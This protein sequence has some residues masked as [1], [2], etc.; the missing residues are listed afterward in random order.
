MSNIASPQDRFA[1]EV[2]VVVLVGN[3]LP[4]A[5]RCDL[6]VVLHRRGELPYT[7][8]LALPSVLLTTGEALDR[9]AGRAIESLGVGSTGPLHQVAVEVSALS[10]D[11]LVVTYLTTVTELPEGPA[12][13]PDVEQVSVA[14][15][16]E[17]S[18]E[19]GDLPIHIYGAHHS[20]L[21]SALALLAG[22]VERT[23]IS[24][25]LIPETFT[26]GQIRSIY[27]AAW[28][29]RLDVR[30]FRRKLIDVPKPFLESVGETFNTRGTEGRPPELYQATDA[31]NHAVP[32][33]FPRKR[34]R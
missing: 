18:N 23:P 15:L 16:H 13:D 12:Q 14:D 4:D 5:S 17:R 7:G 21:K 8:A 26:L 6:S 27:E 25:S 33:R 22:L 11:E 32:I 3:S 9:A 24:L 2:A 29:K 30:N 34:T 1:T 28:N 10:G 20:P 19:R 31:W